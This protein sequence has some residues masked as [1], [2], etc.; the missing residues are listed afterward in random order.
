LEQEL[1]QACL[2]E[3]KKN[4]RKPFWSRLAKEYGLRDGEYLRSTFKAQRK[5]LKIYREESPEIINN[6]LK[7]PRVGI[8]DLETLPAEVYTFRLYDQNIGIEQVISDICLLSWSGKFLNESEIYSDVLTKIEAPKKKDERIVRS[9]WEFIAGCDVVIGHNWSGFDGRILNT[10]FLQYDLPPLKY[11][12]V[13]TYLCAK[14]NFRFTSNK[15]KFINNK[16]GIRNK[17]D[18]DG[19][20][21]WKQCHQGDQEALDKMLEYNIGDIFATEQLFYK[22]RPYIRNFNVALYNE[23]DDY[24]CPVCGSLHLKSEGFYFTSAGKWET[25]R[26]DNCQC[27]SRKKE[28]LLSK[29]KKKV[30]LVN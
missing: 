11:V 30:L 8:V 13:D 9:C 18:N 1:F 22:M 4:E 26:C 15:L 6:S 7:I 2:T 24:Q 27:V 12:A 28:N 29:D 10:L 19:F 25:V 16:L 14:S 17:V 3:W 5:R 21:L 23:I 20:V